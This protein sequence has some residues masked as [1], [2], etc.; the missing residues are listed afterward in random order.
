MQ[1]RLFGAVAASV[2]VMSCASA[3]ANDKVKFVLDWFPAG[4]IGFTH[5][6]VKEGFFATEGL[7]VS[8][9]IGRGGSDAGAQPAALAIARRIDHM[10]DP[11]LA[12]PR[13]LEPGVVDFVLTDGRTLRRRVDVPHGHPARPISTEGVVAKFRINAGY[14]KPRFSEAAI[15][16]M[17]DC[18]M[19]LDGFD[20]VG[21][22]FDAIE[23]HQN[24]GES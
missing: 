11:T 20:D 5:V 24:K 4:Y 17:V 6:G 16:R 14:T 3:S 13:G 18:V 12:A 22:L 21:A 1:K 23:P 2:L 9:D 10:V 8:I 7:D 15:E 19:N